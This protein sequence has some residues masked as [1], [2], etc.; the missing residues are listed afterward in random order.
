[1]EEE[2]EKQNLEAQEEEEATEVDWWS[3]KDGN[4]ERIEEVKQPVPGAVQPPKWN[5]PESSKPF[6]EITADYLKKSTKIKDWLLVFIV[7]ISVGLFFNIINLMDL[8]TWAS[9]HLVP[10]MSAIYIAIVVFVNGY[11]IYA[12][13]ERKPD[14]VFM[15]KTYVVSVFVSNLLFYLMECSDKL[16][17]VGHN[18]GGIVIASL[19]YNAGLFLLLCLSDQ[20]SLVIPE[21][22]RKVSTF[23]YAVVAL[24][25]VVACVTYLVG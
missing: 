24:L 4:F 17:V 7:L 2:L 9:K 3:P 14:A 11:S 16:G 20:V 25:V 15:S 12:F 18:A 10:W 22:Y 19:V 5:G 6:V 8:A 1:M 21:S 13:R 23:N